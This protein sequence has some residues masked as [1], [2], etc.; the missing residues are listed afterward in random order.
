LSILF[1]SKKAES[2][3]LKV[4]PTFIELLNSLLENWRRNFTQPW[5]FFLVFWQV[6]K[7]INFT[8]KLNL[9]NWLISWR[10]G[11][12]ACSLEKDSGNRFFSPQNIGFILSP[13]NNNL[14]KVS[15]NHYRSW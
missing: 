4:F 2:S 6:V 7:L 1:K 11:T 5:K 12:M 15:R 9:I 14:S 8:R 13:Q 3:F 10:R